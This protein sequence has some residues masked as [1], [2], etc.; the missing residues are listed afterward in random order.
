ME[1]KWKLALDAAGDGVWDLNMETNVMFF[2]D[3]WHEIFGYNREE[4]GDR[5]KWV[6]KIHPD[7]IG[8][9]VKKRDDYLSGRSSSY[10]VEVRY[11]CKD[12]SYKWIL[13]RGI[14]I[15]KTEDG[16]PLRFIG[17]HTDISALKLNEERQQET[18]A[19]LA[20]LIDNLQ[21]GIIVTDQHRKIVFANQ[22]FCD[23]FHIEGGPESVKGVDVETGINTRKSFFK[24]EDRYY[25]ATKETLNEK[26]G[27]TQ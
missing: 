6:T 22:W 10:A 14:V 24:D 8:V 4:I 17:T 16:K 12:G 26:H 3:K 15:A 2:S 18:A 1:D 21:N 11:L 5:E 25:S 19:M 23:F 9:A 13:S 20:N 27:Y 7:D